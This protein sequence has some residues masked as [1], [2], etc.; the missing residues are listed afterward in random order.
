MTDIELAMMQAKRD[1]LIEVVSALSGKPRTRRGRPPRLVE[2]A[3][4]AQPA[5]LMP[6][7]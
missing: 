6:V 5:E 2:Q 4:E 3:E 1:V 7:A